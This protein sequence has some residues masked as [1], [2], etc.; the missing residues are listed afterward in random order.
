MEKKNLFKLL[1]LTVLVMV[2]LVSCSDETESNS[3]RVRVI[4]NTDE[5]I[6]V[7]GIK[8][9]DE[10][11]TI[12]ASHDFLFNTDK[13]YVYFDA[14][15]MDLDT[16]ITI[17]VWVNNIYIKDAEQTGIKY[18]RTPN[19]LLKKDGKNIYIPELEYI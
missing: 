15:C 13:K 9:E 5:P 11:V 7:Y 2:S 17:K 1:I 4:T 10:S 3:I 8:S 18:V 16:E 12:T 19:I 6:K 14:E